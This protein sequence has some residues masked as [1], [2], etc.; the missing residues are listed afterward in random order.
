M[1]IQWMKADR[2]DG[3]KPPDRKQRGE[4]EGADDSER[5][6]V[7]D[8]EKLQRAQAGWIACQAR[9][10]RGQGVPDRGRRACAKKGQKV[11]Q[12]YY[13]IELMCRGVLHRGGEIG[14]C[15]SCMNARG[16]TEDE[17][18]EGARPST[19]DELTQWNVWADKVLVF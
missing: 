17:L 4:H 5:S 8:G 19:L 2:N 3:T 12:G 9:G 15:G 14:V 10:Y 6:A 7:W 1:E 11:P 13:N 16:I 18:L